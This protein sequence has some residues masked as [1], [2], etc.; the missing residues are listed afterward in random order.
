MKAKTIALLFSIAFLGLSCN[1]E[2]LAPSPSDPVANFIGLWN[3]S[4]ASDIARVV[5]TKK[6]EQLLSIQLW[7]WCDASF[8]IKETFSR[9]TN[10]AEDGIVQIGDQELS[11]TEFGKLKIH[12]PVA[13]DQFFT[14][15]KSESFFQQ[16][17]LEDALAASFTHSK[18]NGALTDVSQ[19]RPGAV[20]LYK[21]NAGRY[22]KLQV[23]G[24]SVKLTVRWATWN[25]DGSIFDESDYMSL[26]NNKSYDLNI[27]K[28][29]FMPMDCESDVV[30][31]QH[32][33]TERWLAPQCKAVVAIFH[34]VE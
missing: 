18:V 17:R 1:K 7:Q 15:L 12:S 25:L 23:R 19:L 9:K 32:S 20:L 16:V 26:Y 10:D 34:L 33:S 3:G 14:K 29:L 4:S 2:N 13:E 27:G 5:I 22:G 21:T 31:N 30:W 8:C 11:I 6:R 28:E 24:N